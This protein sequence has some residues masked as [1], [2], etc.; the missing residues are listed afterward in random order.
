MV[1]GKKHHDAQSAEAKAKERRRLEEA[2]EEGLE[3]TFPASDPINVT[4]PPPASKTGKAVSQ[5]TRPGRPVSASISDHLT[6]TKPAA[7]LQLLLITFEAKV[8]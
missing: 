1:S 4:Q 5:K 2:L 6:L 3:D 7:G 8:L